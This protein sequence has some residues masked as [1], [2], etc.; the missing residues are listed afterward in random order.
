VDVSGILSDGD[1]YEVRNA[2]DFYGAPVL[3]GTYNGSALVLPMTGLS[4]ATPIGVA[5][6]ASTGSEFNA[7]ILLPASS[8]GTP[9]ATHTRTPTAPGATATHTPTKTPTPTS[10]G[11]G[12]VTVVFSAESGVLVA[13][14]KVYAS[15][16]AFGGQYIASPSNE[17]GTA[18]WTVN[19]PTSGQYVL[20]ARVYAGST[21]SNA[22]YLKMDSGTE[23]TF[24]IDAGSTWKWRR[25]NGRGTS[26]VPM[27][28]NPRIFTLSSGTHTIRLRSREAFTDFDRLI[29]TNDF[30]YV[31]NTSP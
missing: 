3:Q 13:P 31:P 25:V 21:S 4:V 28:V 11:G 19:V 20:W 7:F 5:A 24:D 26:G 17:T 18:T 8:G 1:G 10:G 6:P 22:A 30:N 12:N 29:L 2:Q 27:S 9:T 16:N 15:S 14:M 23:D